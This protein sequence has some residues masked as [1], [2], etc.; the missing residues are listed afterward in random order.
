M[1]AAAGPATFSLLEQTDKASDTWYEWLIWQMSF[2][3]F[4]FEKRIGNSI[5]GE[6]TTFIY[7]FPPGIC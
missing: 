7:S 2:F 5:H 3:P 1:I 6:G 4:Q